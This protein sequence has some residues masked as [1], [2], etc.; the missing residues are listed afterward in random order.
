M[1]LVWGVMFVKNSN[2]Q[3]KGYRCQ[4]FL[5]AGPDD[6]PQVF[7]TLLIAF[8]NPLIILTVSFYI[9]QLLCEDLKPSL[10]FSVSVEPDW[11]AP[12]SVDRRTEGVKPNFL[13]I[14]HCI[15]KLMKIN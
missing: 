13:F 7:Q 12:L 8:K 14:R 15:H 5:K 4:P 2:S 9:N 1:S 3:Y 10:Y 11:A 6:A